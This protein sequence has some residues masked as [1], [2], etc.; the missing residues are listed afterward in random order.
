MLDN[1]D[2]WIMIFQV[3]LLIF[4]EVSL[5][6][7][8][9]LLSISSIFQKKY[10]RDLKKMH[11]QKMLKIEGIRTRGFTNWYCKFTKAQFLYYLMLGKRKLKKRGKRGHGKSLCFFK[12]WLECWKNKETTTIINN[13]SNKPPIHIYQQPSI[14]RYSPIFPSRFVFI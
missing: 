3:K 6:L 1:V 14:L 11:G 10:V 7:F 12:F 2:W 8:F 13:S 9:Y 4:N 5:L